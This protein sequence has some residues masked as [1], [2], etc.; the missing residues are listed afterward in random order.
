MIHRYV[1][2]YAGAVVL[3]LTTSVARGQQGAPPN[4]AAF[5]AKARLLEP[6]HD[7]RTRR[8]ALGWID[9]H[10]RRSAASAAAVPALER[11]CRKEPD[12][13]LR[14]RAVSTL[15]HVVRHL[16]R[17]C[18][19]ALAEALLDE[20]EFVRWQ[21]ASC[22]YFFKRFAPGC[23]E[24]L[25]RG[26]ESK[27]ADVRSTCLLL[28]A[29]AAGKDK[30]SLEAFERAKRDKVFDVRHSAHLAR[31]RATDRLDEFL[32]YLVRLI[33]DP[34]SVLTP[35][36]ESLELRKKERELRNLFHIGLVLRVFEW[37]ETRADE[38]A[39]A[40]RKLLADPS[41]VTRRG[42]A[43]LIAAAV[44]RQELSD[45]VDPFAALKEGRMPKGIF[46]SPSDVP[47]K[48]AEKKKE[49]RPQKSKVALRLAKLNVEKD[50][51]RLRDQDPDRSV[52]AAARQALERLASLNRGKP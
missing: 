4:E 27:K 33:E 48:P 31:F 28:L 46:R 17:P 38:F 23:V 16:D 22:A 36:P 24:V 39:A 49:P 51:R 21:A 50:L 30:R 11:A 34:D 15:F 9:L 8:E 29:Q 26:V 43:N 52:R 47:E 18:P 3:L 42:A 45:R 5:R 44:V 20:E 13:E 2:W 32:P 6:T 41:P 14:Q 25:L 19:L 1:P 7:L 37:S 10:Y 40:L 35:A 12:K